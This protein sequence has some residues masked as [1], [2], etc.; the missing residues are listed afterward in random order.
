MKHFET[1]T[2]QGT[3]V[4]TNGKMPAVGSMA[5]DF[6][7]V[8]G[9]LSEVTLS[10]LK[11]QRVVLNIVPSLETPVCAA[12]VRKF[13]V[14]AASLDHV[15]VLAV[16]MDLPFAQGRF[17]TAEG[18]KNVRPVSLFRSKDFAENYGLVIADGPLAGLTTRAVIV[19]DAEGKVVYT[20]LVPEITEEPNY[21]AALAALK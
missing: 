3:E 13:N 7:A 19:V 14:E 2:F 16:S 1:V 17:C 11:G 6:T 4:H 21:E 5:P 18:I 8:A 9:D 20:Q 12:S 15:Q 10:S